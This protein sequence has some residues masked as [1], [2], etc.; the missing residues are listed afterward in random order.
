MRIGRFLVI[1][2]LALIVLAVPAP[3]MATPATA[4]GTIPVEVEVVGTVD[5]RLRT[6]YVQ[7]L[8]Q[9]I[10]YYQ[11]EFGDSVAVT[12]VRGKIYQDAD[13][14]RQGLI[15]LG[16]SEA[17]AALLARTINSLTSRRG[18]VSGRVIHSN[19]QR[20]ARMSRLT[21]HLAH[22]LMH[23]L[24][25]GWIG[26][27]PDGPLWFLEGMADHMAARF[28]DASGISP[29]QR[30]RQQ[31]IDAVREKRQVLLT[32]PL[33]LNL[34]LWAHLNESLGTHN[35]VPVIYAWADVLYERLETRTSRAAF[36]KFFGLPRTGPDL[37]TAFE[38]AFQMRLTDF[39]ADIRAYIQ[40][41]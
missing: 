17:D 4:R 20:L 13:V 40:N 16:Y 11:K 31:R 14:F 29:Y 21:F 34:S 22:E 26:K 8:E 35:G 41:L 5:V 12:V 1:A 24:Q 32:I 30:F 36:V 37:E 3:Q 10:A 27:G 9:A 2:G 39:E 28:E 19:A 23:V 33:T 6:Q 25:G 15:Q 7:V 38:Q 18:I